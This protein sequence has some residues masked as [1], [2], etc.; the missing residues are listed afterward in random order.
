ME[1]LVCSVFNTDM[2]RG[3]TEGVK[4]ELHKTITTDEDIAFHWSM[5]TV[6]VEEAEGEVLL[7]MIVGLYITIRG[8]SFSKSLMEMYKQEA[9]KCTQKAKSLRRKLAT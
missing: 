9:K 2:L 7:G 1:L 6:E 5:L 3:M 8:F 4:K